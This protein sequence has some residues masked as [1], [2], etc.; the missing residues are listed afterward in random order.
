MLYLITNR[1]LAYH[2]DFYKI[3]EDAIN[4]GISAIILREKD[5]LYDE[6]LIMA[7]KIKGIIG[8]R[9]VKLIVNSNLE[10]AKGVEAYGFH[11]SFEK[12]IEMKFSFKGIIGVSVHSLNEAMEAEKQGANYLLVGHIF[13]TDCKKGLP[14]RGIELIKDIRKNVSIPIIALG[15]ITTLNVLK[16]IESGAH[17]VAVMSTIM[18][19][20][21][22]FVVTKQYIDKLKRGSVNY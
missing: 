4:G 10:V 21:D 20:K 2:K 7:K 3:I 5:L 8:H 1:K 16:V 11:V 9:S 17:G 14:P 12:F 19:E 13:E 22:P 18:K 15:G 6:L